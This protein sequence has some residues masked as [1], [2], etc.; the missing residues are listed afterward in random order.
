MRN[1]NKKIDLMSYYRD[2]MYRHEYFIQRQG[3]EMHA[4]L[5][6]SHLLAYDTREEV[7]RMYRT[8]IELYEEL[9]IPRL[10]KLKI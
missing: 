10:F 3:S 5:Y 8:S 7:S 6:L 2:K 9:N 1:P 4:K